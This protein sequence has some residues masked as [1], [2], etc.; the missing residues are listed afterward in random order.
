ML[1]FRHGPAGD[2]KDWIAEG[3]DDA[4]RPLTSDGRDKTRKAAAGLARIV[5]GLDVIAASPLKRAAQTADELA[6]FFKRAKRVTLR[7]LEPETDPAKAAAKTL[8]LGGKRIAVV[9]HEPQLSGLIGVLLGR[10]Q[11]PVDLKKAGACLIELSEA[12]PGAGK[13]E[14]L[15]TPKQLRGLR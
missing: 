3:R 11:L 6:P 2:K 1:V 14:W 13:L 9:G 5:D 7:E 10:P 15:L 8:S 12:R 4:A